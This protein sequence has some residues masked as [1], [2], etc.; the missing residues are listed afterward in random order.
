MSRLPGDASLELEQELHEARLSIVQLEAQ[1]DFLLDR[2]VALESAERLRAA[3]PPR[4]RHQLQR[5]VVRL[6]GGP[7]AKKRLK[8]SIAATVAG[9][10]E[11]LEPEDRT[12]MCVATLK[13]GKMCRRKQS[14]T[15]SYCGYHSPLD[16]NSGQ[17]Y[18]G[19]KSTR[20]KHCGNPVPVGGDGLCKYHKEI[21]ANNN[22][23]DGEYDSD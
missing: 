10:P 8:A 14:S 22:N 21:N 2:V 15:S 12:G 16:P 23:S 17:R 9:T 18:C 11:S 20:G 4:A 13:S 6:S 7:S 1:R 3:S 19:H 5:A